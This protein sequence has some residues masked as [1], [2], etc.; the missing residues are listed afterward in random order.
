MTLGDMFKNEV[1]K[2]NKKWV[3][4]GPGGPV[5]SQTWSEHR[6]EPQD[7]FPGPVGPKNLINK[8]KNPE[9][10]QNHFF[11]A[12]QKHFFFVARRLATNQGLVLTSKFS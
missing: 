4:R 12:Y 6:P 5:W 1:P 3:E 7:N 9:K 10:H 2:N 8:I 11:A